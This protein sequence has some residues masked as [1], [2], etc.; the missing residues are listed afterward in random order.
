[1]RD[2]EALRSVLENGSA[3]AIADNLIGP[4][5]IATAALIHWVSGLS[6]GD[7]LTALTRLSYVLAVAGCLALVRVLVRRL[8][9]DSPAVSLPAQI[10]FVVLVFVAGTWHWSDIPWSHFYA[11]FLVVAFYLLR[12]LPTRPALAVSALTGVVLA[13]LALT[14]SFEFL[15]VLAGWGL[16]VGLF[17]VLRIRG[18]SL[19]RPSGI[20]MGTAA[21][22]VTAAAVYAVTGKRNAFLLY[23]SDRGEDYGVLRPEEIA[24][25]PRLD[26]GL[27]PVK[28]GQLFL[29]PCIYALCE[30]NEYVGGGTDVW[31][32]PLTIQLPA[33]VV[34]PL[35]I[36]ALAVLVV[37]VAKRGEHV[38]GH[39]RELRLLV[40]FTAVASGLTLGYVASPWAS[41]T[42][43]G[44][45]FARDFI[46]PFLLTG[47]VSVAL[48]FCA[49]DHVLSRRESI[50]LPTGARLS[51]GAAY[52]A[53]AM[54]VAVGLVTATLMAR[55]SGLPRLE[56]RHLAALEYDATCADARCAVE[57]VAA[58]PQGRKV[59]VPGASLLTVGC[60]GEAPRFTVRVE[61]PTQG[62][63]I[64]PTCRDPR[65]V[66]AWPLT[67]GTPPNSDV[68]RTIQVANSTA[69]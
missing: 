10:S 56:S 22:L 47:L 62:F 28:L 36:L 43:L 14:R 58:N 64:P 50:R 31:K 29:D 32:Q 44:Y 69:G 51:R 68:L 46:L 63:P 19:W 15:A 13:L 57:V 1:M 54:L 30:M 55:T 24:P 49:L 12:L 40:E 4:A 17:A 26:V 18:P 67:M 48:G 41:S 65:L 21:F 2:L 39:A 11:A 34:L 60:G 5:Y 38:S 52:W 42:A 3:A 61:K 16:A 66:A 25:I 9:S 59:E 27:I 20:A 37:R 45:G 8:A 33:L 53:V 6:P 35:C 23:G 7:A